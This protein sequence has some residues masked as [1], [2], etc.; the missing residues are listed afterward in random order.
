MVEEVER[1]AVELQLK[2]LADGNILRNAEINGSQSCRSLKRVPPDLR[3][4]PAGE[5]AKAANFAPGHPEVRGPKGRP[6][7]KSS[8]GASR[9][10]R[11]NS[12]EREPVQ[13][14]TRGGV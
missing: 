5:A 8:L 2:A 10:D 11:H 12:S 6:A 4:A 3:K 7:D 9:C 1:L 14:E 13:K